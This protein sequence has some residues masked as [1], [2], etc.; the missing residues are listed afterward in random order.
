MLHAFNG[1]EGAQLCR[2]G[3]D[4]VAEYL[5]IRRRALKRAGPLARAA[6]KMCDRVTRPLALLSGRRRASVRR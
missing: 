6:G 1:V 5:S 2:L 3:C 4:P